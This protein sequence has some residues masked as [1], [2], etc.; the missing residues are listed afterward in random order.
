MRDPTINAINRTLVNDGFELAVPDVVPVTKTSGNFSFSYQKKSQS[1]VVQGSVDQGRFLFADESSESSIPVPDLLRDN[2]TFRT[3]ESELANSGFG[4][5]ATRMQYTPGKVSVTLAY[6]DP[7]GR[8]THINAAITNGTVSGIE[9][10]TI[11]EPS[12]FLIPALSVMLICLLSGGVVVLSRR[13]RPSTLPG[14]RKY[15]PGKQ[16]PITRMSL[17]ICS[18]KRA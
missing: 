18:M 9:R 13:I 8:V 14:S 4:R 3:Y 17:N 12:P 10:E 16:V 15:R 11:S 7:K 2:E 1:A 6:G 5:N